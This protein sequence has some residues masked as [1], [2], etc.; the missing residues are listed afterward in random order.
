MDPLGGTSLQ[1]RPRRSGGRWGVESWETEG[2][3]SRW[4]ATRLPARR[5]PR[6]AVILLH[7]WL[8]TKT[9]IAFT[10]GLAAPLRRAGIE[11][12]VPRLPAHCERTP[13]GA[14][15]GERCLSA[16]LATTGES[17][18]RAV[19]ETS[20]L[21][22]WLRGRVGAVGLWGIS[23]GGWVAAL[24]LTTAT[25]IDAAVLWT[26][27]V[28]PHNTVWESPLTAS[29]RAALIDGGLDRD[30]TGEAFH[31]YAP[32]HRRLHLRS[33]DVVVIGAQFD[34]VV[35]PKSLVDLERRW[36]VPIR[37]FPHGHISLTCAP[38]ARRYARRALRAR[39]ALT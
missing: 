2:E 7:G 26:P 24:T 29:I 1:L 21:A 28:D 34:N 23:L 22:T 18:R 38:S 30:L 25:E 16:D 17:L 32:G 37:W 35:D 19:A 11:V 8:A 3:A 5:A 9:Q 39:L 31:R 13:P 10:A 20:A 4:V 12:W 27:I 36:G 6:A 15:S 33:D 14:I